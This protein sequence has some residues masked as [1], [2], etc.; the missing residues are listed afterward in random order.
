VR[1][2]SSI[3]RGYEVMSSSPTQEVD[4]RV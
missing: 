3:I 2:S 4:C 1:D